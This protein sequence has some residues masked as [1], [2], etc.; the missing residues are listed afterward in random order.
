ME[1]VINREDSIQVLD[2]SVIDD[3]IQLQLKE[4]SKVILQIMIEPP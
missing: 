1:K 2:T 3:N 4:I